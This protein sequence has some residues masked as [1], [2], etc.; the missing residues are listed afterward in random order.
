MSNPSPRKRV[1]LSDGKVESATEVDGVFALRQEWVRAEE[2]FPLSAPRA[3]S[4]QG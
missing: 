4:R 2:L 3:A 1:T